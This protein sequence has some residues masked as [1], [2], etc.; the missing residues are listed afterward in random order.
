M[1]DPDI[2]ANVA[3]QLL[4]AREI[5]ASSTGDGF[6]R[7]QFLQLV[8]WGL[9]GGVTLGGLGSTVLADVMPDGWRDVYAAGPLGPT[10]GVLVIIGMYGGNDGLNT[11]VPYANGRYRDYRAN[12]AIPTDQLHILDADVGLHPELTYLKALWDR[13]QLAIVQG[14]G[15]PSPDLSH[16]NSMATWMSARPGAAPTSGWVGR[17]LDGIGDRAD[18]YTAATIGSSLPLHLVGQTRRG[19]AVPEGGFD[20]GGDTAAV[21]MRMYDGVKGFSAAPA[22][23][24]EWHDAIAASSRSQIDLAQRIAPIFAPEIAGDG[25][26]KSLA[27][28]AR[29]IN[30]DLGLRVL[31]TSLDDFDHHA[32]EPNEHRD[33]M[34][35]LNA[36]IE[37][38]FATLD[39]RFADRVTLMTFSEFGRTPWS[40]DSSGTDH[41]T[42]A[43]HFVIGANVQG[44][45]YGQAP[46][47]STPSGTAL[48]RWDRLVHTVDF[49]SLYA[50]MIDGLLGG[51]SSSVLNGAFETIPLLRAAGVPT[52]PFPSPLGGGP[53]APA[54]DFVGIVPARLLDTREGGTGPIGAAA[55]ITLQVSGEGG[56]PAGAVAAVL[57]VTAVDGT[58]SSYLT[59]WPAGVA[60]PN[61]SSLNTAGKD[62]VPNLV[63]S[64]LGPTGQV[65][66]YNNSG[67]THCVVDVVGYFSTAAG[68]R[69]SALSPSRILDTRLGVGATAAP[70]L[71]MA[72]IVL[73]VTGAGGVSPDADAVVMNVT[74][75]EPTASGFVTVW[76]TGTSMPTASNLNFVP[77]QTVPNLVIAK[78]GDGGAVS[79]Y[80]SAGATH[81]VA[82]VLGYFSSGDG[83]ARF[84]A[85]APT[86]LL[87]TRSDGGASTPVAQAALTLRVLARGGVPASGVSA[88]VLN[89]T[90]TAGTSNGFVT[91]YPSG[92]VRPMASNLNTVTN[93]TRANLVI[94]KVGADGAVAMFN[95]AGTVHLI[96]DVVGYF[97]G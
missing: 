36:G 93:G 16:F 73:R 45:L 70:V 25:L 32:D 79:M 90:A 94:A 14:V 37:T 82:D 19:T 58:I 81:L 77:S 1:L 65:S 11:V 39:P 57:N 55:T 61:T 18:L 34:A 83:G 50:T 30:A 48:A 75:T 62:V 35:Q 10:E 7:R 44:G 67:V 60:K 42:A 59:V 46:S 6:N 68:S 87:D 95:N 89:V 17:W 41:G 92:E 53:T 20:Y 88:V 72:P 71:S 3:R 8:G 76:P 66:I 97:T 64:K 84:V 96:A 47:L 38:F 15:Y 2:S 21:D 51:G 74:V 29:L 27:V 24:G 31:D 54:A 49:R 91:V 23:R 78:L 13:Q 33:R 52:T 22:G 26:A 9:G 12:V 85:L 28:A 4:T 56:V 43:P 63:V 5:H 69:F 40:N 80:N 86:R